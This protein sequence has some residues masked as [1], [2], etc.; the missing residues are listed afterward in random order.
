M[1]FDLNIELRI[2]NNKSLHNSFI[3]WGVLKYDAVYHTGKVTFITH[4]KECHVLNMMV[5]NFFQDSSVG[6][7][8]L[9]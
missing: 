7:V 6:I 8:V 5:A 1:K 9:S 2:Q 4:M 3:Q